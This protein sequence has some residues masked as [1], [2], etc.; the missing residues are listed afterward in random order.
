MESREQKAETRKEWFIR[1][2]ENRILSGKLQIGDKLPSERDLALSMKLSRTIVNTGIR[3]LAARGFIRIVPRQGNF[4][5]DYIRDG[6]LDTLSS[7]IHFNDGKL[8]QCTLFSLSDFRILCERESAFLAA[9]HASPQ[10]LEEMRK[11]LTQMQNEKRDALFSRLSFEFHREIFLATGNLMY[12]L[13]LNAFAP[14]VKSLDGLMFRVMSRE[15]ILCHLE[16][17]FRAIVDKDSLV[18]AARMEEYC[19][20]YAEKIK[21]VYFE[22]EYLQN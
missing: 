15:D 5:G 1:E 11:I 19:R 18:A 6:T 8:D 4:V 21:E 13:L 16:R 10:A 22:K 14:I 12:P 17:V 20:E 9:L 7:I 2:M 3:E